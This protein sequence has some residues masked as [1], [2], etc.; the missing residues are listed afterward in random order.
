[1]YQYYYDECVIYKEGNTMFYCVTNYN[2]LNTPFCTPRN[3]W[4]K[5]SVYTNPECESYKLQGQKA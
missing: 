4:V 3:K 2:K 5:H 1:M